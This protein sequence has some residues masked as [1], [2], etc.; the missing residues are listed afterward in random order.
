MVSATENHVLHVPCAYLDSFK[1]L[2]IFIRQF[3][4]KVI[5][6]DEFLKFT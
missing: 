6:F 1:S 2:D 4:V 5:F 3:H